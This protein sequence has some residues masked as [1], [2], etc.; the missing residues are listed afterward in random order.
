MTYQ[1]LSSLLEH[2]EISNSYTF[3]TNSFQLGFQILQPCFQ[4]MIHLKGIL[5]VCLY[6]LIFKFGH[7]IIKKIYFLL[8]L[9]N[10]LFC[11]KLQIFGLD[12]FSIFE[13]FGEHKHLWFVKYEVHIGLQF[14]NVFTLFLLRIPNLAIIMEFFQNIISK[15]GKQ[16]SKLLIFQPF[17]SLF[18]VLDRQ[19]RLRWSLSKFE[20]FLQFL[21]LPGERWLYSDVICH[22]L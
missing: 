2:F 15:A 12:D 21:R 9:N 13:V 10:L 6:K 16:V 17:Y 11:S 8:N 4:S 14:L 19:S 22:F 5:S 18:T 1:S 20:L 7:F 3:C